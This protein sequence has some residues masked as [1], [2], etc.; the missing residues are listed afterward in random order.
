MPKNSQLLLS[1]T[2]FMNHKTLLGSNFH[3]ILIS[4]FNFH[5]SSFLSAVLD[6]STYIHR[7]SSGRKKPQ[8]KQ[9]LKAIAK[10]FMMKIFRF[11]S[12]KVKFSFKVKNYLNRFFFD[13]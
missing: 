7:F 12:E 13:R 3:K 9:Q 6:D 10:N 4:F 11:K 2:N 1:A 8:I 5:F